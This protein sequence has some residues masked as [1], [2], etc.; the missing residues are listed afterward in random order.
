MA[1][2]LIPMHQPW[3]GRMISGE[4]RPSH[5]KQD[6]PLERGAAPHGL[7]TPPLTL[8]GGPELHS[9][10]PSSLCYD[11]ILIRPGSGG[12]A[13]TIALGERGE[14]DFVFPPTRL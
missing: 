8:D 10:R 1:E 6:A 12:R 11:P 5:I 7:I 13:P 14:R 3:L 4:G 2:W 9:V